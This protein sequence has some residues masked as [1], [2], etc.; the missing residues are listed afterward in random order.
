MRQPP[1]Q[2]RMETSNMRAEILAI[3]MAASWV[4]VAQAQQSWTVDAVKIYEDPATPAISGRVLIAGTKIQSVVQAADKG[5]IAASKAPA[6]NGGV[7]VAGFQNSHV[8]FTGDEFR[9]A[10]QQR[11]RTLEAALT[12]MLT[13][14]G[15]TTVFDIASERD[16]TL[17]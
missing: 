8:H 17:A 4:P 9:D 16:N 1:M 2:M 7:I 11:A 5:A 15:Y 10:P 6:C 12:D 14:Y 3:A 13:R